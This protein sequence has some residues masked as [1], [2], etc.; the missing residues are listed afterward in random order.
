MPGAWRGQ[1][2]QNKA[3]SRGQGR[4]VRHRPTVPN[5]A[6][7]AGQGHHGG[8]CRGPSMRNK[9][10]FRR[11]GGLGVVRASGVTEGSEDGVF[12]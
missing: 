6:N 8:A 9:A 7:L 4:A 5:K 1:T 12:A 11:S 10:N 2:V 3:N